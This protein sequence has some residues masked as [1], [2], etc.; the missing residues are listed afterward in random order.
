MFGL[1]S[2]QI[3][4]GLVQGVIAITTSAF[5]CRVACCGKTTTPGAVIFSSMVNQE[6]GAA[7]AVPLTVIA[8]VAQAAPVNQVQDE[9]EKPP[10]YEEAANNDPQSFGENQVGDQYQRFE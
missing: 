5:S 6:Q 4:T 1:Y 2:V 3:L 9:Q 8:P 7:A 10:K